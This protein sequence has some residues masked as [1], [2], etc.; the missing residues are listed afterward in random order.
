MD[1]FN[2][3]KTLLRRRI[4]R[5]LRALRGLGVP[6]DIVVVTEQDVRQNGDHH[7]LVM[8]PALEGDKGLYRAAGQTRAVISIRLAGKGSRRSGYCKDTPSER[9][10]LRRLFDIKLPDLL[11][12]QPTVAPTSPHRFHKKRKRL[13]YGYD[14]VD[15][16]VLWNT[17]ENVLPDLISKLEK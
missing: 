15:I 12:F 4:A 10:I 1:S 5:I 6:K 3:R 11:A 8:K 13:I 7:S 16:D 9:S 2:S 14:A 17:V